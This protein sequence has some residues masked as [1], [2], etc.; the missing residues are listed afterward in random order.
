MDL[1]INVRGSPCGVPRDRCL[2]DRTSGVVGPGVEVGT[3]D[4]EVSRAVVPFGERV[5]TPVPLVASGRGHR[6]R[7]T[8][9]S[10][11]TRLKGRDVD[12]SVGGVFDDANY[13]PVE[14]GVTGVD[15]E[16]LVI[17]AVDV[18]V[19][20]PGIARTINLVEHKCPTAVT[21]VFS[22]RITASL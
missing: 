8:E 4:H 9:Q 15:L 5:E 1:I 20:G 22:L 3:R 14:T 18:W 2:F 19:V 13:R 6:D 17:V 21:G 10:L 11:T 7:E 16:D 12:R